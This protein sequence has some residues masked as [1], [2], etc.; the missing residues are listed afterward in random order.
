MAVK[1]YVVPVTKIKQSL[2]FD[3]KDIYKS[4]KSFLKERGYGVEEKEYSESGNEGGEK[5]HFLWQCK[6]KMD[7]YTA[8]VIEVRFSSD[9]VPVVMEDEENKK[10]LQE[11]NVSLAIGGFIAKDIEDD[12]AIRVKT[13][14]DRFLRELYDKFGKGQKFEEYEGKLKKDIEAVLYDMKT[15]LKMQR[16]D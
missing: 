12:W 2:T 7:S 5:I 10:A 8:L 9:T 6:K 3:I 11:G 4:F 13:G 14:F 15:Y 16:F 1:D